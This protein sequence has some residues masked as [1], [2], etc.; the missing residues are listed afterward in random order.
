[1]S[2]DS[3]RIKRNLK[4]SRKDLHNALRLE[5]HL[6]QPPDRPSKGF[7][8]WLGI[9]TFILTASTLIAVRYTVEIAFELFR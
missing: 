7:I 5:H 1:M 4:R 6:L 3:R 9:L 2:R 8:A